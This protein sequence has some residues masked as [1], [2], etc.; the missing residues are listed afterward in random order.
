MVDL[1]GVEPASRILFNRLHT[2]LTYSIYLFN[3]YVNQ[4]GI[5]NYDTF[6]IACMV[7]AYRQSL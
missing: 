7:Q 6:F 5:K 3:I 1:A 4:I 2:V